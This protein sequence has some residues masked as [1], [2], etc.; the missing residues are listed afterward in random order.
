VKLHCIF[1]HDALSFAFWAMQPVSTMTTTEQRS[2]RHGRSKLRTGVAGSSNSFALS[3]LGGLLFLLPLSF[4]LSPALFFSAAALARSI[5]NRGAARQLKRLGQVALATAIAGLCVYAV[6][7]AAWTL[8]APDMGARLLAVS[9]LLL[10]VPLFL[11]S[12][13]RK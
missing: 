9:A 5:A 10:F 4:V 7:L 6:F 2:D 12:L 11:W 3:L 13:F 8:R 1:S